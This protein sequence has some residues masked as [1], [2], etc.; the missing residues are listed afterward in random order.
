MS[1]KEVGK[2]GKAEIAENI[3]QIRLWFEKNEKVQPQLLRRAY[4]RL[5]ALL[6]EGAAR[7]MVISRARCSEHLEVY[8]RFVYRIDKIEDPGK[9]IPYEN[10]ESVDDL[11]NKL[12]NVVRICLREREVA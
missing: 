11:Y 3:E 8:Q 6:T 9:D 10:N 1:L 4:M 5:L 12:R 7:H 2:M